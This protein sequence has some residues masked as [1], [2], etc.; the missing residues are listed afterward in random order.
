MMKAIEIGRNANGERVLITSQM[1]QSTHMHVIGGSGKGKSKFLEWLIRKDIREGHGL[2]LIDWHGT[3]YQD[4]LSFCAQLD[5]GLNDD[6]RKVVLLNPSQPHFVTG[7][8]PFMNRG[9]DVSV[10]VRRRVDATIRPWGVTNTNAMPTFEYITTLLYTFAVEQQQTLANSALLLD[11]TQRELRDYAIDVLSTRRSKQGWRRLQMMKNFRDWD[12]MVLS[13]ENR[14]SRFLGSNA[15]RR[16]MGLTSGNI[17]LREIMDQ[18]HILL[19]NLGSSE[20]LDREAAKVFASLLLNEFFETSMV[21]AADFRRRGE[22][23]PTFLLYLDEFQEYITEDMAGMLDQVRKGGLHM[24]LAHQHLGHLAE[25]PKLRKSIFTNAR[26]RAVLGGLDYEDGCV[27]ANEMFLPDLNTRQIKKAYY[28]TSML[29]EEQTRVVKSTTTGSGTSDSENWSRGIGSSQS[30]ARGVSSSSGSGYSVGSSSAV[31]SGINTGVSFS[32]SGGPEGASETEGWFTESQG[33]SE[34]TSS[35]F[36]ESSV[37]FSSSGTTEIESETQ[38]ESSAWG[39]GHSE[40][41]LRSSGESI[42]PVWVPIPV[43]EL[44]SESEWS[45]EEKVSK[46]AEML[47]CQMKQHCFIKLDEIPTQPLCIPTVRDYSHLQEYLIEYEGEL[48]DAQGAV[49]ASEVDVLLDESERKFL[50]AAG[51]ATPPE[52]STSLETSAPNVNPKRAKGSRS[53]RPQLFKT[54]T[55]DDVLSKK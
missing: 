3:L 48:Y 16:F 53:A 47:I 28:H 51:T 34:F 43:Q 8:N 33:A 35:G 50:E 26:I 14:I 10:Q 18:G 23:P 40:S 44:G 36:T 52:V 15:I 27:M 30:I 1:R 55:A 49:S 39:G 37:D 2:C 4:V 38:S 17:N 11:Y 32:A 22:K 21:R 20:Y 7:F 46:V 12:A 5:V 45:R 6:F 9:G 31:G 29:Y 19:L 13:T 54:L 24:V 41:S 25:N 42:V